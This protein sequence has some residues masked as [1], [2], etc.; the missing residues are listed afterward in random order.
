MDVVV[1]LT[2]HPQQVMAR[3]TLQRRAPTR[4]RANL[5]VFVALASQTTAL[6]FSTTTGFLFH[7][8]KRSFFAPEPTLASTTSSKLLLMMLLEKEIGASSLRR[9]SSE[10][11]QASAR[12][13]PRGRSN[14]NLDFGAL[15]M[16]PSGRSMQS[17]KN[18]DTAL[19]RLDSSSLITSPFHLSCTSTSRY[20]SS[21][22]STCQGLPSPFSS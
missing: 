22:S 3:P 8:L 20:T 13:L 1:L 9:F 6:L 14:F 16:M 10:G 7:Y 15:M 2:G 12:C 17:E 11:G 5:F 18:D 21:V 4:R 19:L